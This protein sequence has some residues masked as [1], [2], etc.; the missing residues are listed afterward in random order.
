MRAGYLDILLHQLLLP[1]PLSM[2]HTVHKYTVTQ[3]QL[4]TP[5]HS[6]RPLFGA[7]LLLM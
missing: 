7:N 2:V 5:T 3:R 1:L 4:R 6:Q